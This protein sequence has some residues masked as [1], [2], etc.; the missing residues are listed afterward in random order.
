MTRSE[1]IARLTSAAE[2]LSDAQINA[3]VEL[4]VAMAR[5]SVYANLPAEQKASIEQG[6]ADYEAGR[7]VD[8]DEVFAEID[9]RLAAAEA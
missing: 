3:L 2:K 6:I 8:A 4:S 1:R 7:V 9:K 5:P